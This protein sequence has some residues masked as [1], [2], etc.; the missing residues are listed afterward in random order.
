MGPCLYLLLSRRVSE[1]QG[2]Q[3]QA[4]ARLGSLPRPL[5]LAAIGL[6]ALLSLIAMLGLLGRGGLWSG[7][8]EGLLPEADRS[9]AGRTLVVVRV[10]FERL[11]SPSEGEDPDAIDDEIDPRTILA[12][13]GFAIEEAFAGE[14]VPLAPPKTEITRWLDAHALYLLPI[15]T[16]AA[17]A[18][19]LADPALLAQVQG[20]AARLSSPLYAVSGDQPRR[21]PLAIHELTEREAGRLGHVAEVPGSDAPQVSASGDL[22]AAGGDRALIALRSDREPSALQAELEAALAELP[23]AVTLVDPRTDTAARADALAH[24]GPAVLLACLA[25]LVLLLSLSLRK[26]VPVLVMSVCL[27][28]AWAIGIWLARSL[29]LAGLDLLSVALAI[30]LLGFGCDAALRL[31]TLGKRSL[32]PAVILAAALAPLWLSPYPLWRGWALWWALAS[33]VIAATMRVVFPSLLALLRTDFEWRRPGFRL[34]P[35]RVIAALVCVGLLGAGLSVRGSLRYRSLAE[36]PRADEGA[37][38]RELVEQFFDPSMIVEAR[39]QPDEQHRSMFA[40][41]EAAVLDQAAEQLPPLTALVPTFARRIDSPASFVLPRGELEARKQALAKLGLGERMQKLQQLLEDRGLRAEAFTEFIHGAADI[42]DLPSADMALDGPLGP[43]IRGYLIESDGDVELRTLIELRGREG[44]PSGSLDEDQLA[45]L[46]A[47]HGPAF[48]AMIDQRELD[49][50]FGVVIAAG[51]WLTALVVWL[52]TANLAIALAVALVA[53]S[54]QAGVLVALALLQQPFG[55]V[56]LPVMLAV[57]AAAGLAGARACRAVSLGQP[58]AG[59][60]VLI[61]GACQI[62]AGAA[63]LSSAQPLW[64]ELG[65]ALAC[66]SA[67]ACGLGLFV[68]P[69]LASLF[70]GLRTRAQESR[71]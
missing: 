44:L 52:G 60:G 68:T 58:I 17:L 70:G 67:L 5:A 27:L 36:L 51:L 64:R 41:A 40:T 25:G 42:E 26:V 29:G 13:A 46:P 38:E 37:G 16:H 19:R 14:R 69:G 8:A 20:L 22:I 4:R 61:G 21:D 33:G 55:P 3:Q 65:L 11:P 31:P 35:S 2:Q 45:E 71:S 6:W 62:V 34:E 56:L 23:V 39:V 59:P 7:A 10:D 30:M 32:G 12:E 15:E 18:E 63:L 47:I 24:D 48:A 66:G 1:G 50:R 43:W 53:L 28:A 9:V 57:G 54:C 49:S